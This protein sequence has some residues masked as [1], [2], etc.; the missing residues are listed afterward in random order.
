MKELTKENYYDD[1]EYMSFSTFKNF[2][3]NPARALADYKGEFDWFTDKTALL[4]GNYLHSYF[5]G[6]EAHEAFVKE[7]Y[8][9]MISSRGSTKGELKKEYKIAQKMIDRLEVEPEFMQ[10]MAGTERES[11]ITG[12]IG[13][14]DWKGKTDALNVESGYFIDFKTVRSLVDDGRV[15]SDEKKQRVTF[16]ENR[17]Y[18]MQMA[19]YSELL[20][21]KYGYDFTPIIWAV[22]KDDEPLA[23]PYVITPETRAAALDDLENSIDKVL[24]YMSGELEAPLINDGSSF[25]NKFHRVSGD[26]YEI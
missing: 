3:A 19:V 9:E 20:K 2:L 21:Q 16:I 22:S 1:N 14:I 12:T 15:W 26:Y 6:E 7:N 8:T 23:K 18:E 5:E 13:G 4:V 25:Y 11:I 17:K 24:K 10:A